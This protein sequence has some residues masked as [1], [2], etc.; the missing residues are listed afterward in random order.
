MLDH[1]L[2]VETATWKEHTAEF[3]T[4]LGFLT[5]NHQHV[6]EE[7]VEKTFHLLQESGT[8]ALAVLHVCSL[9]VL[10]GMTPSCS[11]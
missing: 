3:K 2:A 10:G 1:S 4:N 8:V 11:S 6:L 7:A 9:P 5:L